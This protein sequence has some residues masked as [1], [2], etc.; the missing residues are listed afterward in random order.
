MYHYLIYILLIVSSVTLL[1]VVPYSWSA[2]IPYSF[3]IVYTLVYRPY[4]ELRDNI[5]SAF[6][7]LV[8]CIFIGF[9]TYMQ[10]YP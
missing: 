4:K 2:I 1:E 6:N 5:R 10:F 3:M 8:I 7:M 9:K